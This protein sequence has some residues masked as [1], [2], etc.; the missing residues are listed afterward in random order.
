MSLSRLGG[1]HREEMFLSKNCRNSHF[2]ITCLLCA[3]S[4]DKYKRTIYQLH[5]KLI[6]RNI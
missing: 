5:H 6:I 2:N 4:A 1:Y 3:V